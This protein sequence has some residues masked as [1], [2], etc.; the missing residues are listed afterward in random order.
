MA[1]LTGIRAMSPC[2]WSRASFD[3]AFVQAPPPKSLGLE[4][5]KPRPSLGR[6]LDYP[7]FISTPGMAMVRNV[8]YLTPT[9]RSNGPSLAFHSARLPYKKLIG[10]YAARGR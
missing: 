9:S 2:W 5:K 7:Y 10:K 3:R 8:A 6:G 1:H 4:N